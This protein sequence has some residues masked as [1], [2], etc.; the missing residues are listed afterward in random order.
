MHVLIAKIAIPFSQHYLDD[1]RFTESYWRLHNLHQ[2][3]IGRINNLQYVITLHWFDPVKSLVLRVNYERPMTCCLDKQGILDWM[4]VMRKSKVQ[5]VLN[6][7]LA[8][9]RCW[10]LETF[11]NLN[12]EATLK[13]TKHIKNVLYQLY[14]YSRFFLSIRI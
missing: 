6:L 2:I 11:T 4:R 10:K 13:Q 7:Y 1:N 9:H 12:T 3:L 8:R 14:W 5:P